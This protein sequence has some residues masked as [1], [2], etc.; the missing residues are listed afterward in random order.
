MAAGP[1]AGVQYASLILAQTYVGTVYIG[2]ACAGA[3]GPLIGIAR[4]P[5]AVSLAQAAP[6]AFTFMR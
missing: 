4:K 6:N 1:S 5:P 2:Y 3:G